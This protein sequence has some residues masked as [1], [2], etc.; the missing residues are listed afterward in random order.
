MKL[1]LNAYQL[2]FL[3]RLQDKDW[4]KVWKAQLLLCHQDKGTFQNLVTFVWWWGVCDVDKHNTQPGH[5]EKLEHSCWLYNVF[6]HFFHIW[7]YMRSDQSYS[8]TVWKSLEWDFSFRVHFAKSDLFAWSLVTWFPAPL[9]EGINV[10]L[11]STRKCPSSGMA[12]FFIISTLKW[13]RKAQ[14]LL[15]LLGWV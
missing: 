13:W 12:V 11:H 5:K 7:W 3:F 8:G 14:L 2:V 6:F 10:T 1:M 4:A 15:L 9:P